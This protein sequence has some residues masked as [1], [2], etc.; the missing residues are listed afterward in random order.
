M[1]VP[2]TKQPGPFSA[3]Q[4][5]ERNK[6]IIMIV[7]LVVVIVAF[8]TSQLQEKKYEDAERGQVTEEPE[9]VVSVAIDPF[10]VTPLQGKFSDSLEK[11]RV[12]LPAELLDP[13]LEYSVGFGDAHWKALET[14]DLDEKTLAALENDPSA[15]RGEPYR[16][17]GYLED[18][19]SRTRPDGQTEYKGW[20]RLLDKQVVHFVLTDFLENAILDDFIRLDGLF[21]KLY[22]R[23]VHDGTLEEGPLFVGSRAVRSFPPSEAYNPN[24]L[25]SRLA[26]VRDDTTKRSTGLGAAV[27]DAQWL[28]INYATSPEGAEIDWDNALELDNLTM[29]EVLKKGSEYRG[30]PFRIPISQ[31]MGIY[32]ESAGE[33]PLRLD[34]VTTGWIANMTWVNQ[35]KVIRF[36][37]PGAHPELRDA[38]LV[39]GRGFFL[40]NH[41]Y[42]PRDGGL[43]QSPYFVLTELE[44]FIPVENTVARDVLLAVAGFSVLLLIIFP[45]LLL[46][47]KRK[48]EAL[49]RDLVRRRQERRR[50]LAEQAGLAEQ[51]PQ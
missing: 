43:R 18:V 3:F 16:V 30:K 21:V 24:V 15:H 29:T 46:R 40:K 23:E 7:L 20:V 8:F 47:D 34:Q 28:L 39:I 9:P 2:Q 50:K 12:L 10:D 31:N 37:M 51:N 19:K 35:A 5:N 44:E 14:K 45:I 38:K 41:N 48:S 1:R 36:I 11:N 32:T 4:K 13:F 33:N 42:E 22:R 6:L 25:A 27:F 17:R 49:Q 26:L